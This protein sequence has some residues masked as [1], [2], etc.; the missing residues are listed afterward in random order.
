[1]NNDDRDAENYVS[2]LRLGY[3]MMPEHEAFILAEYNLR[4]FEDNVDDIGLNREKPT[5]Q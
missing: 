2:S 4:K 1:M 3:E 5:R